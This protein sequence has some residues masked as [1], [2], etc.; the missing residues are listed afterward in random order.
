MMGIQSIFHIKNFFLV[1]CGLQQKLYLVHFEIQS[2]KQLSTGVSKQILKG[3]GSVKL[4]VSDVF[5]TNEQHGVIKFA[6]TAASFTQ[7]NDT[8]FVSL[9]M[10][11]RFGK[12]MKTKQRKTGGA[13][14]EQNRIKG[15]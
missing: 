11:N 3:K 15:N 7:K 4:N 12:P 5:D 9:N 6:N 10:S 14:D 2:M 1:Y 13:G 8:K